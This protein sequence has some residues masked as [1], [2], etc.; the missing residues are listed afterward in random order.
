MCLFSQPCCFRLP[1]RYGY[2]LFFL[3]HFLPQ[4]TQLAAGHDERPPHN[5]WSIGQ[6]EREG[7]VEGWVWSRDERRD[8]KRW[9]S[10]ALSGILHTTPTPAAVE[11]WNLTHYTNTCRGPKAAHRAVEFYTQALLTP[12]LMFQPCWFGRS[13]ENKKN[14]LFDSLGAEIHGQQSFATCIHVYCLADLYFCMF[15]VA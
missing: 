2:S 14:K 7:W 13:W 8:W 15:S 3:G 6:R 5:E 4:Q 1:F 11:A 10:A 9:L 12:M